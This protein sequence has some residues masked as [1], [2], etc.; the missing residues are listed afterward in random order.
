MSG[1][2]RGQRAETVEDQSTWFALSLALNFCALVIILV[3]WFFPYPVER[4]LIYENGKTY[5]EHYESGCRE[6]ESARTVIVE[7]LANATTAQQKANYEKKKTAN[8]AN[9]TREC[10]MAAQY[11]AAES[12][13]SMDSSNWAIMITTIVAALLIAMT[14]GVTGQTLREA[15]DATKAAEDTTIATREVGEISGRGNLRAVSFIRQ[16]HPRTTAT[17]GE[18]PTNKVIGKIM[19]FGQSNA[20]NVIILVSCSFDTN[21]GIEKMSCA[22]TERRMP[23]IGRDFSIAV[24]FDLEKIKKMQMQGRCAVPTNLTFEIEIIHEDVFTI[25]TTRDVNFTRQNFQGIDTANSFVS[26]GRME[27][28]KRDR[29]SYENYLK[30][31][32]L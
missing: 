11:L 1:R 30:E 21:D 19:H 18:G 32:P 7:S 24:T 4:D 10:D 6:A 15:R 14:L 3:L 28:G 9:I 26:E 31:F 27:M 8:E 25:G 16:R 20:Y 22:V 13:A 2:N 12:A 23:E 5:Y 17:K 29:D